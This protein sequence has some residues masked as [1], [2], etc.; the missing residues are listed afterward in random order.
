MNKKIIDFTTLEKN[1]DR[2]FVTALAR[3]LEILRCFGTAGPILGNQDL[4]KMTNL[5]KPTISRL[6]HTLTELGYL[7]YVPGT[8]QL[9]LDIGVLTFG[10]RFL[11]NIAIKNIA[12]PYM[13]DLANYTKSAVAIAARDRLQMLYLHV[14]QGES[15]STMRRAIGSSLP[16]HSSSAGRACL[17]AMPQDEQNFILTH[18]EKKY[19]QTE[20]LQIRE[21][22]DQAFE[23]YETLGCCFSLGEWHNNVNAVAVPLIHQEDIYVFNCGGPNFQLSEEFLK[24][25]VAPRLINM[26]INIKEAI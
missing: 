21:K 5:P 4:A 7:K 22:L 1:D 13:E 25:D 23:D 17:A 8:N 20:W 26:V 15:N 19:S 10:Q 24:Q 2:Q 9:Q 16:I 18:L 14:I 6:T 3:G 11:N 12:Q